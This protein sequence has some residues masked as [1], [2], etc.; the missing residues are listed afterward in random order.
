MEEEMKHWLQTL[1]QGCKFLEIQ[2]TYPQLIDSG[3][4]H[5]EV[6]RKKKK[7]GSVQRL[8]NKIYKGL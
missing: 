5:K 3:L 1:A 8:E 6:K 2:E 7:K 4:R